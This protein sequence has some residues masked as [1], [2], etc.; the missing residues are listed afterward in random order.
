MAYLDALL[1]GEPAKMINHTPD[2]RTKCRDQPVKVVK[3]EEHHSWP[4]ILVMN[5]TQESK[6]REKAKKSADTTTLLTTCHASD[7][8]QVSTKVGGTRWRRRSH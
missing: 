7:L 2:E 8:V 5:V 3:E 6:P 4:M 1:E